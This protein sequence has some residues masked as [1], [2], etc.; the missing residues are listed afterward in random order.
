MSDPYF[1]D[2]QAARAEIRTLSDP[3]AISAVF[4]KSVVFADRLRSAVFID[5]LA[6]LAA[7][8]QKAAG[9]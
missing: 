3:D 7:L 8:E 6:R 9:K 5:I 2:I 4:V 1:Q